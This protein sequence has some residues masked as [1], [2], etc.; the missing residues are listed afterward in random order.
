MLVLGAAACIFVGLAVHVWTRP[1]VLIGSY[2]NGQRAWEQWERRKLSGQIE[3]VRTVR[4][5]PDGQK[6]FEV[7][8]ASAKAPT[9]YYWSPAGEKIADP[10][11]WWKEYSSSL[12][13]RPQDPGSTRP[14]NRFLNWWTG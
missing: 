13:E 11:Q 4:W 7:R 1:Y 6:A 5:Y 12:P 2:S 8:N 10:N 9:K 3:H 14:F